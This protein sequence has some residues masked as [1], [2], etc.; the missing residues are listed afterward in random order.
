VLGALPSS[1][2]TKPTE[3]ESQAVIWHKENMMKKFL[4]GAC[5]VLF[6][7]FV[8][9]QLAPK[10]MAPPDV[11]KLTAEQKASCGISVAVTE[12]PYYVSGTPALVSGNL[13]AANLAG[14]PIQVIGHVYEGLDNSKPVANAKIE[15]WHADNGGSYHPNSNGDISKY[16][17]EDIALRGF[18]TTDAS[19]A[20]SF[21][22]VYPGEYSGRTRHI[23]FKITT[24]AK[25]LTTQLIIP[26]LTGDALTFDEDTIAQGLPTCALLKLD[27]SAKPETAN[28]NFRL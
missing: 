10:F 20:Y 28:F 9:T 18:I 21:T 16:K 5:A 11:T 24:P 1:L 2:Q 3:T 4:L 13:N 7:A 25:S 8:A 23:H 17:T 6:L 26:A 14:T 22:T 27:T 15:I 19:G 12:G